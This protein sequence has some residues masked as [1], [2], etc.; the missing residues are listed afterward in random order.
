MG[1]QC[2]WQ[3]V[4]KRLAAVRRIIL[5]IACM[6]APHAGFPTNQIRNDCAGLI[7]YS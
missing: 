6:T 2:A 5:L 7:F 3:L 1:G 4:S